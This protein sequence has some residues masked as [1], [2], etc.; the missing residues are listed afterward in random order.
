MTLRTTCH[1]RQYLSLD[2]L[3]FNNRAKPS[4]FVMSQHCFEVPFK[5]SMLS[6]RRSLEECP[7]TMSL[8]LSA[9]SDKETKMTSSLSRNYAALP[10][11]IMLD[12]TEATR[13]PIC[14][15]DNGK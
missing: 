8:C 4:Y 7:R 2:F 9:D 11:A 3:A 12:S 13:S 14:C 5:L 1:C 10:A 6:Q 15:G